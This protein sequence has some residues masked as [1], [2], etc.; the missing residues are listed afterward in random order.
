MPAHYS[1]SLT[2]LATRCCGLWSYQVA[3]DNL[4]E[5]AGIRLSD[6]TIGKIA[7]ETAGKIA[8]NMDDNPAFRTAF[9]AAKGNIEFYMD[10]TFVPIL[11]ADGTKE[12]REM[13]VAAFVKRLL[14]ASALPAE[15][16]SR[17][18][19]KPSVVYAFAAITDKED[20]QKKCQAE[21]RRVGVGGVS[22]ALG[23]GAKWIGNV[24]KE[25]FGN[26]DECLDIYHALEHVSEC[27]KVLYG[28]GESFTSWLDKMRLVLLS[29]GFS[30]M[31]REL[32]SLKAELKGKSKTSKLQRGSVESLLGYLKEHACRLNYCERLSAGR[33]IGSGLIE[34]A[35]KNLVG[36]RL[37]QT[38]ACWRL[39][40][41]NKMALVCSLLY[42]DQ[43]NLAW[44]NSH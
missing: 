1:T 40:R 43:W 14:G 12:W 5:L 7:N 2:R 38:G 10:G 36:R 16:A 11:N 13:K 20:F 34:G 27:G 33:P 17:F 32:Q 8:A 6:T 4:A 3:A 28:E 31:E 15:W 41:A 26:V 18:L 39:E 44:K 22:S 25:V 9:Q 19:P 29:E 23:D 30:G 42:A 37:K 35:C 24:I 21:R